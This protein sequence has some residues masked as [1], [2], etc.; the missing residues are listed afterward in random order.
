MIVS[1]KLPTQ[2][3][4]MR[5]HVVRDLPGSAYDTLRL[6][7]DAQ[8]PIPFSTITREELPVGQ[9]MYGNAKLSLEVRS[10]PLR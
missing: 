1:T 8:R 9:V 10:E 3:L 5:G 2:G 4:R 7:A 6:S